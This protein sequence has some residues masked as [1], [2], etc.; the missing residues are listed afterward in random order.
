[1]P[2][3][4]MDKNFEQLAQIERLYK[5]NES[6]VKQLRQTKTYWKHKYRK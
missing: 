5:E 1:M 2:Q 4:I 6:I 3:K